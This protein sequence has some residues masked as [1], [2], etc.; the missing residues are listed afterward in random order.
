SK[1][2]PAA[3]ALLGGTMRAVRSRVWE[4]VMPPSLA[5]RNAVALVAGIGAYRLSA[6]IPTLRYAP[7]DARSLARVLADPLVCAFPPARVVVVCLDCCHA[8]TLLGQEGLSLRGERDLQLAPSVLQQLSGRGR[9]LIAS[10]DRGQKSIEAEEL[11]HG[12][13][14]YHLLRG[15]VEAGDR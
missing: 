13:F 10:C 9:F 14:T 11:R 4:A 1:T 12:L 15:L 5:P 8:G 7:R 2:F 6:R 3:L